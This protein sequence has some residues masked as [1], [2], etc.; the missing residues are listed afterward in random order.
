MIGLDTN[1]L[2]RYLTKD[3][4][5]QFE[6][7]RRLVEDALGRDERLLIDVV[8][9]CE[10]AW[11]L[12]SVYGYSRLEIAGVLERMFETAQFEIQHAVEARQALHD[13][14]VTRADFADALIGRI[15]RSLCARQ[16]ATLDRDLRRLDTVPVL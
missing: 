8:V 5:S 13:V 6:R 10:T 1:V 2:V 14:R 16:T 3:D 11:V 7:A 4:L 15:N 12:D 9:L